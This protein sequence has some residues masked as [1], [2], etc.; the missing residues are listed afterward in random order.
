MKK[1]RQKNGGLGQALG[2]QAQATGVAGAGV[3]NVGSGAA[4]RDGPSR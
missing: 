3:I 1:A 4:R 2:L